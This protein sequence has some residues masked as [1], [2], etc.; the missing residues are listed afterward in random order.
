MQLL[1]ASTAALAVG[2]GEGA[3]AASA[4][5]DPDERSLVVAVWSQLRTRTVR[6]VVRSEGRRVTELGL[7]LTGEIGAVE[8]TGL[9]PDTGYEV[10]IA[11][12]DLQLGPH[13]VRTAP[14]ADARRP[15]RLAI[16]AP[17]SRRRCSTR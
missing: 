4:V 14:P 13:R 9:A 8:V 7:T 2:C 5:L 15:V 16:R 3:R 11:I 10:T 17:N 1:G 6:V 12:G